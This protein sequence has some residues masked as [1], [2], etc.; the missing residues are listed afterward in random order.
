MDPPR[1]HLVTWLPAPHPP[2]RYF[3]ADHQLCI[4]IQGPRVLKVTCGNDPAGLS[5]QPFDRDGFAPCQRGLAIDR[6][7]LLLMD[8]GARQAVPLRPDWGIVI[9][10]PVVEAAPIAADWTS[11]FE[12]T[13][14]FVSSAEAFGAVLLYPDDDRDIE[15]LPT[16]P[17]V[18]DYVQDLVAEDRSL[19]RQIGSAISLLVSGFDATITT[20][21]GTESHRACTV[22]YD[23]PAF[24]Q[25]Q[26][27]MLWNMY[28]RARRLDRLSLV[29]MR[30]RGSKDEDGKTE[31][32]DLAYEWLPFELYHNREEVKER[33]DRLIQALTPNAVAFV[34]GPPSTLDALRAAK[35]QVQRITPV[36]KL[37]TVRIHQSIL[38]RAQL[39]AGVT[40]YEINSR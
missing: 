38:P 15:E 37:P 29:R 36:M 7:H 21:I 31:R 32:Y 35:M 10:P 33:I 17:F 4:T 1:S 14:P 24:A 3:D 12:G 2:R 25:K 5:Y 9:E 23:H 19:A 22:L 30:L 40:L 13:A 8:R 16:Q 26:A 27:Q 6:E 11:V 28:A 39:K 20:C 18:A 34:V